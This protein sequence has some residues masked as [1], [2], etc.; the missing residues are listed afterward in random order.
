[1]RL[2]RSTYVHADGPYSRIRIIVFR[3]SLKYSVWHDDLG[4]GSRAYLIFTALSAEQRQ[5]MYNY[6]IRRYN[7]SVSFVRMARKEVSS[8]VIFET[9]IDWNLLCQLS[10]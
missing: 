4:C 6:N 8:T 9:Q 10:L 2:K 5:L 3:N 1:M 7:Y